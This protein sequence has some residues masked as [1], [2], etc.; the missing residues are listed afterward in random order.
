MAT[1]DPP[2]RA[3]RRV[4]VPPS[5]SAVD[6]LLQDQPRMLN[7][8]QVGDLLASSTPTVRRLV[9]SGALPAVRLS[10]QWRVARDDLRTYLLTP[11]EL[12]D[13]EETED[14]SAD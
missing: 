12:E 3:P 8:A 7:L 2:G 4:A 6:A 14:P 9:D 5:E 13:L 10:R 11:S 1:M